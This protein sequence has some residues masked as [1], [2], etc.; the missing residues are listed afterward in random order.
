MDTSA[1]F[2]HFPYYL[3]RWKNKD[4]NE[5]KWIPLGSQWK[6]H[7]LDGRR[8]SGRRSKFNRRQLMLGYDL[9]VPIKDERAGPRRTH[10]DR[11]NPLRCEL[12]R[13]V[14]HDIRALLAHLP[15]RA[16]SEMVSEGL[17]DRIQRIRRQKLFQSEDKKLFP[18]LLDASFSEDVF[19]LAC[20]RGDFERRYEESNED[21]FQW[22]RTEM[23]CQ[24][25][26]C[27]RPELIDAKSPAPKQLEE[28]D[29]IQREYFRS[30]AREQQDD[31]LHQLFFGKSLAEM[32]K[33][34]EPG[35]PRFSSCAITENAEAKNILEKREG[36]KA[37]AELKAIGI[38]VPTEESKWPAYLKK[39]RTWVG[40][41]SWRRSKSTR[42]KL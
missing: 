22:F 16:T 27:I 21:N 31:I 11:R 13:V 24:L 34:K 40:A 35:R 25:L 41:H 15:C 10:H 17:A 36:K 8:G 3:F 38:E 26:A 30:Q 37:I 29:R 7:P 6:P 39:A 2:S 5:L 14:F 20:A 19:Q 1:L 33:R 4:R 12:C 28:A 18:E 42:T 32:A 9:F 23:F